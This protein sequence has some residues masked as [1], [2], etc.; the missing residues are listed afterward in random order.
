MTKIKTIYEIAAS[1]SELE[2]IDLALEVLH[3]K[4][5]GIWPK[6][7]L[8]YNHLKTL[9]GVEGY[10]NDHIMTMII[11]YIQEYALRRFAYS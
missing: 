11:N 1:M 9:M 3:L 6:N 5:K 4:D 10:P 2:H 7:A 8:A